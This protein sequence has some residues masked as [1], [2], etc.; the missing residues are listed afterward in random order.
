[1]NGSGSFS[2]VL[3]LQLLRKTV[4]FQMELGGISTMSKNW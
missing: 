3:N 4:F 1:M 2:S